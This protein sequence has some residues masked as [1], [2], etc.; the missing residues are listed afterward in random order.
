MNRTIVLR[1]IVLLVLGVAVSIAAVAMPKR[2]RTKLSVPPAVEDEMAVGSFMVSSDCATCN[3]GYR[4]DQISLSG[5]DKPAASLSET[6]FITNNTDRTLTGVSLYVDYRSMDGAQLHKR[7][8]RIDC[9]VPPGETRQLRFPSWDRQR[10][11]YYHGSASSVKS[12]SRRAQPFAVVLDP[13]SYTLSFE[14]KVKT[15][16]TDV[17]TARQP[18]GNY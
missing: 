12:K 13:V 7:F 3:N 1:K 14:E 8:L 10:S 4:L 15:D 6:L 9:V 11:F 18:A 17:R 2:V 16:T 5:F